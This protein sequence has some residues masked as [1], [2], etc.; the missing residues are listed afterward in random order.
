MFRTLWNDFNDLQKKLLLAVIFITPIYILLMFWFD[1]VLIPAFILLPIYLIVTKIKN[2]IE[3]K[4]QLAETKKQLAE[5]ERINKI[6]VPELKKIWKESKII[7]RKYFRTYIDYGFGL[8]PSENHHNKTIERIENYEREENFKKTGLRMT[9]SE[10]KKHMAKVE[11]EKRLNKKYGKEIA[12]KIINNE[13]WIGMTKD[14]LR[15]VK[16]KADH[17]TEKM[18]RGKK[19][20]EFFYERYTNRLGNDSYKFRVVVLNDEVDGWNDID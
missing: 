10:L 1:N 20:E 16:G 15:E 8:S 4:K 18:S 11:N 17:K 12:D 19:R 13:L 2:V 3:T 6:S 5:F 9:D 7:H 14:I